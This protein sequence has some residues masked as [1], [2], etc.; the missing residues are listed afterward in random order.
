MD[1]KNLFFVN[2]ILMN[3]KHNGAIHFN[4]V[5]TYRWDTIKIG[6]TRAKIIKGYEKNLSFIEITKLFEAFTVLNLIL[7]ISMT[8][9]DG[10]IPKSFARAPNAKSWNWFCYRVGVIQNW[11]RVKVLVR[12]KKRF[13]AL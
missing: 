6:I 3:I 12:I 8:M 13:K 5:R 4:D 1:F 2:E 11:E 10:G 7:F 9:R